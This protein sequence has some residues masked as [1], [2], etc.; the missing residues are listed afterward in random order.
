MNNISCLANLEKIDKHCLK[1]YPAI[2]RTS[3]SRVTE[4]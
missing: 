3:S 2:S 1:L 4:R